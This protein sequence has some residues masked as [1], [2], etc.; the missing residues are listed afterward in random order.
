LHAAARAILEDLMANGTYQYQ[1]DFAKRYVAQGEAH[2]RA[3]GR[4]EGEA[5][6][7]AEGRAQ[8]ILA[9][10]EA[11]GIEVPELV[12]HRVLGCTDVSILDVWIARAVTANAASD[13]VGE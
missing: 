13:V 12:R 5:K 7:K 3:E 2:G 4:A 10:L 8:A 6:G 1:S 11:R 9:V